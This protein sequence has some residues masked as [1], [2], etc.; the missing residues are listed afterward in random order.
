MIHKGT[1]P[2]KSIEILETTKM[3]SALLK[4]MPSI[5]AAECTWGLYNFLSTKTAKICKGG[6]HIPRGQRRGLTKLP[7]GGQNFRKSDPKGLA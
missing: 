1:I 6:I 4:S 2:Q 3:N 5:K 7:R